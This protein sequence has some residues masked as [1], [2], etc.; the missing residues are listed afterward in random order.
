VHPPHLEQ[1]GDRTGGAVSLRAVAS[2]TKI[3]TLP[4]CLPAGR[5]E[6]T[7]GPQGH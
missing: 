5:A 7:T 1:R 4:T 3:S 6:C 2:E